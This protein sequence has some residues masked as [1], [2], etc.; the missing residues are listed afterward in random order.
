M[1]SWRDRIAGLF[2]GAPARRAKGRNSPGQKAVSK[3]YVDGGGE[4]AKLIKEA[5]TVYRSRRGEAHGLLNHALEQMRKKPPKIA[6]E[7][8][9]LVRALNLHRA[10]VGLKTLMSHDLR[11]HLVL[12]GIRGLL[13]DM[14]APARRPKS[15]DAA[16]ARKA[17]RRAAAKR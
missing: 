14:P 8:E 4:R 13:E 1:P 16:S 3:T 9:D 7:S 11:R 5:M 15:T 2:G 12:S 10:Q 17:G 6:S